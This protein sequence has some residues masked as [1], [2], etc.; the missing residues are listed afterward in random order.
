MSRGVLKG[1][2]HLSR[3]KDK[4]SGLSTS[5]SIMGG[6]SGK[7]RPVMYHKHWEEDG[8]VKIIKPADPEKLKA[9]RKGQAELRK[10]AT[11]KVY[12]RWS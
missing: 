9:Y 2:S 11:G 1:G 10:I 8:E 6:Y 3:G 4:T 12:K 5:T 7:P